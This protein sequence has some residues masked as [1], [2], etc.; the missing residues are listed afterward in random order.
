MEIFDVAIVGGGPA[1]SSCAAFCALAGLRTLVLEREKFPREKVCGDCLN[2]SCWPMLERLCLAQRVR[3]LPHSKLAS[4]EFI[5]ISGRKVTVDL[6][7]G[8][9]CEFSVKRSLFDDLVLRRAR[10]LGTQVRE[11]TTV[12]ALANSPESI[13][14]WKIETAAGERFLARV[15]IGADGRNSTVAR[16][17]NLLPHAARERVAL[18]AHIPLPRNFGKRV[19]LQF[20]REGYA[21]QAPVNETELNLCLVGTP[22]TISRLRQWAERHFEVAANQHWR[23]ITPLTRSPVPSAHKNLLFIGDAARVVEPFTGEGIYYAIRSGE[24]AA[25]AITKIVRGE[26]R[27]LALREFAGAY[28]EMYR[29][30]LWINRLARAAVLSPRIASVFVHAAQIQPA[31]LRLLTRKIVSASNEKNDEG[32]TNN[33]A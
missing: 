33:K 23:T 19:V 21:G 9:D 7:A 31:I 6:P 26:D 32:R 15:L 24:L 8:D 28:A 20:L 30:R 2:P 27:Q 14:G 3:G 16:L 29:G 17:C 18:Q 5:A 10:D 1:G 12:T 13:R 25:N 22:P 4:V 11:E